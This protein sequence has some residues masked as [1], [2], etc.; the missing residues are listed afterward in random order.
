M[1]ETYTVCGTLQVAGKSAGET[2][3]RAELDDHRLTDENVSSLVGA[4]LLELNVR[5]VKTT[6]K[7]NKVEE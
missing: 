3:T 7:T 6:V 2:V 5:P 4:G 1:E